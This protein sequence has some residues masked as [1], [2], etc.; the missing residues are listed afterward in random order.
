VKIF[1][2]GIGEADPNFMRALANANGGT[3]TAVQ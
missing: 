3:F 2:I 1:T